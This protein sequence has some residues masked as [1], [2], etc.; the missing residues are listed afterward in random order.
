MWTD[1]EEAELPSL[2]RVASFCL[3]SLISFSSSLSLL[4]SWARPRSKETD[5]K[6]DSKIIQT[7]KTQYNEPCPFLWR[8]LT[9]DCSTVISAQSWLIDRTLVGNQ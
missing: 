9:E 3:S 4:S 6:I 8:K 1:C 2:A 7:N 5:G